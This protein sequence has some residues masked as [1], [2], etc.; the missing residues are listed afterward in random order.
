[1][2]NQNYILISDLYSVILC[3]KSIKYV[4][5]LREREKKLMVSRGVEIVRKTRRREEVEIQRERES[6]ERWWRV[7]TE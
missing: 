6:R 3:P 7:K 5:L 2:K 1:M 4:I